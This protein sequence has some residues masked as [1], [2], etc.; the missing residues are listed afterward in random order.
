[1]NNTPHPEEN[2]KHNDTIAFIILV[3]LL[4]ALVC[5]SDYFL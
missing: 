2:F 4:T 5:Y 3:L 1:M